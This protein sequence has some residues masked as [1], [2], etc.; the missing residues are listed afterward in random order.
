MLR[1]VKSIQVRVESI[2]SSEVSSPEEMRAVLAQ[3]TQPAYEGLVAELKD[4][5]AQAA[6]AEEVKE[7]RA[8]L[9]S[10]ARADL[11]AVQPLPYRSVLTESESQKIWAAFGDR[12]Q[13]AGVTIGSP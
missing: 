7:Y 3:V 12:W 5:S 4:F 9:S 13:V 10:L 2:V 11:N 8:F 1:I 6:L